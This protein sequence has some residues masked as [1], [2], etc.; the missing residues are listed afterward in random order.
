M[1]KRK[2]KQYSLTREEQNYIYDQA[3][4][5]NLHQV[6]MQNFILRQVMHR[7]DLDPET[8]EVNLTNDLRS[9]VV[10]PIEKSDA[11]KKT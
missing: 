8:N 3:S 7:L 9:I 4:I 6:L 10:K 2:S 11:G 5:I 1:A